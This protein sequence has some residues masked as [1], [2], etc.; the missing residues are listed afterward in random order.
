MLIYDDFLSLNV[1]VR[2]YG[3]TSTASV[4]TEGDKHCDV[5]KNAER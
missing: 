1:I 3:C 4:F 2:L 5:K